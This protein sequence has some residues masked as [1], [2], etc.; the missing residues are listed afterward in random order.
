[1]KI[2][3]LLPAELCAMWRLGMPLIATHIVQFSIYLIDTAML[4]FYAVDALAALVLA[5]SVL[6]LIFVVGT[7]FAAIVLTL[8]AQSNTKNN[9]K[10]TRHIVNMALWLMIFYCLIFLP[11]LYFSAPVL[12]FLGQDPHLAMM[13]QGYFRIAALGLVASLLACILRNYLIA[14]ERPKFVFWPTFAG[15][16]INVFLNWIFIFGKWGAPEMGIYGA[17]LASFIAQIITLLIFIIYIHYKL[18]SYQTFSVLFQFHKKTFKNV[19]R[20]G[21][22]AGITNLA[23]GSFFSASSF[24]AGQLGTLTLAAHG[25]ALTLASI[26]FMVPFGLSGAVTVLIGKSLAQ[27]NYIKLRHQTFYALVNAFGIAILN[28]TLFLFFPQWLI[29]FFLAPDA[30]HRSMIVEIGVGMLF[31][32]AIFQIFDSLQVTAL[33]LLRGLKDTKVPLYIAMVSYWGIGLPVSYIIGFIIGLGGVGIWWGMVFGL[34]MAAIFLF[35]RFWTL[36]RV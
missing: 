10:E 20:L 26:A 1:M 36:V 3:R 24:F 2:F 25:I 35:T 12:V 29:G 22:P 11:I 14:L 6:F 16:L 15:V 33:G 31:V 9:H 30:L 34:G 5:S 23:E 19:L 13:A 7:G 18:A 17:A 28:A 4:G 8:V 27:E 32:A 21:F